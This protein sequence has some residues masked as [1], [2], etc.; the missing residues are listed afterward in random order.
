MRQRITRHRIIIEIGQHRQL[1]QFRKQHAHQMPD[2]RCC[3]RLRS[4]HLDRDAQALQPRRWLRKHRNRAEPKN[5][6]QCL[7][8]LNR[9]ATRDK[10]NIS[11]ADA[12]A[13][14]RKG[15][16]RGRP[17]ELRIGRRR[18]VGRDD[19]HGIWL[20]FRLHEKRLDEIQSRP[21]QSA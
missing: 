20:R 1:P 8:K 2:T 14:V 7:V 6:Q 10:H 11:R 9:D 18:P 19:R 15:P 17:C 13:P 21:P 12:G 5:R 16:D 4:H 3:N